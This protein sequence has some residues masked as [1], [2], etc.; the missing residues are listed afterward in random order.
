[1]EGIIIMEA[2]GDLLYS[3]KHVWVKIEGNFAQVGITG[4]AQ[5]ALGEIVY[6][7]L[8]NVGNEYEIDKELCNVESSKAV[9]LVFTPVSG[10]V[11]EINEELSYNLDALNDYPYDSWIA[12]L[13]LS[14]PSETQT[15]MD[16]SAY[17]E[18]CKK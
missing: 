10:K 18:F 12:T 17:E 16:A 13:E 15:L 2:R 7:E 5:E 1:M 3:R 14:T 11:V 8:P 9:A 4:F 6:L